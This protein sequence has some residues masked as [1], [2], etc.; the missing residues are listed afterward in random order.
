MMCWVAESSWLDCVRC[1]QVTQ[2]AVQAGRLNFSFLGNQL[3]CAIV[4][5]SRLP[6]RSRPQSSCWCLSCRNFPV[7]FLLQFFPMAEAYRASISILAAW[8][9][10]INYFWSLSSQLSKFT[11]FSHQVQKLLGR[12]VHPDIPTVQSHK[13]SFPSET[14]L[15][16][17]FNNE[18]YIFQCD[19][20]FP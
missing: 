9:G 20:E 16:P 4:H 11:D 17:E 3:Q 1:W 6:A 2:M 14:W 15:S 12:Q 13:P 19:S 5:M 10:E 18:R 8:R 7:Q